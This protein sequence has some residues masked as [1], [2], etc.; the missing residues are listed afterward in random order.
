MCQSCFDSQ[1]A[2]SFITP[3]QYLATRAPERL[4]AMRLAGRL[5]AEEAAVSTMP[6]FWHGGR[7]HGAVDDDNYDCGP[8][9]TPEEL[10][11]PDFAYTP[12]EEAWLAL[13]EDER[14]IVV[15]CLAGYDVR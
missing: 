1:W 13:D 2:D 11:A 4:D 12:A 8:Y 9:Y 5:I 14:S 6:G 7:L 3:A 10:A 15:A